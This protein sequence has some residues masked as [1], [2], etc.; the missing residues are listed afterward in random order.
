MA[1]MPLII[2]W[3]GGASSDRL[4]ASARCVKCGKRGA[5]LQH[6]PARS[7]DIAL[8]YHTRTEDWVTAEGKAGEAAG[9]VRRAPG[10]VG[11]GGGQ[12]H[13]ACGYLFLPPTD[14]L[15]R[16]WV[17]QTYAFARSTV[18]GCDRGGLNLDWDIGA[19]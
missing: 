6:P 19:V 8:A 7:S 12:E 13:S 15:A 17:C 3:G 2:R 4:R 18:T 5:D 1:L 10:Q 11:S 9:G 16:W 14:R